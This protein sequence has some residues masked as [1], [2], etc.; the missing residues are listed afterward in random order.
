ML[1]SFC[2]TRHQ[3]P[4]WW[5]FLVY[6]AYSY[7]P[8]IACLC[9]VFT[10]SRRAPS[11]PVGHFIV[12]PPRASIPKLQ[13][14]PKPPHPNKSGVKS[15]SMLAAPRVETL[16]ES[17]D[18]PQRGRRRSRSTSPSLGRDVSP[19]AQRCRMLYCRKDFAAQTGCPDSL[20]LNSG[21]CP[22]RQARCV[23]Q[24]RQQ[25]PP[26]SPI[27]PYMLGNGAIVV[28]ISGSYRGPRRSSRAEPY[29]RPKA[30]PSRHIRARSPLARNELVKVGG[31]YPNGF[32]DANS[33]KLAI[34]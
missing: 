15:F 19:V 34:V 7:C 10:N 21:A 20:A 5:R 24:A 33:G 28:R 13:G 31:F 29:L 3:D 30:G 14:R 8:S 22:N 27:V 6:L 32:A 25:A 26:I 4:S 1:Y 9:H 18:M 16:S 17:R 11:F 12:W 2:K 23:Q